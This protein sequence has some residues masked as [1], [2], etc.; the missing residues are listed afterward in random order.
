M[1]V[2]PHSSWDR[3]CA[4]ICK[5]QHKPSVNLQWA[6]A[7]ISRKEGFISASYILQK[8][9]RSSGEEIKHKYTLHPDV[10]QFIQARYNAANVSDVS[11]F[12]TMFYVL[13]MNFF[14]IILQIVHSHCR[15]LHWYAVL[16]NQLVSLYFFIFDVILI[17]NQIPF[18][19]VIV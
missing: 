3:Q 1:K 12:F 5:I 8:L 15:Y 11:H 4:F 10:P 7:T 19:H 2:Q 16:Y 13:L 17:S 14:S 6:G 9:Y 18:N